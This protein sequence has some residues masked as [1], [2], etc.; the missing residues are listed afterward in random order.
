MNKDLIIQ[1]FCVDY[2]V[3][4]DGETYN[5]L[6]LFADEVF[7]TEILAKVLDSSN[8]AMSD[9]GRKIRPNIATLRVLLGQYINERAEQKRLETM[10]GVTPDEYCFYCTAGY[11]LGIQQR[12]GLWGSTLT[13]GRCECKQGNETGYMAHRKPV[14]PPQ[15]IQD[16]AREHSMDCP[17]AADRMV[18]ERTQGYRDEREP[19][20]TGPQVASEPPD[21]DFGDGWKPE[22]G[23]D[24]IPF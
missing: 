13:I 3:K 19:P 9:T 22:P 6:T 23:E 8:H 2:D 4:R 14:K 24:P 7:S 5:N 17:W 18:Y 1:K 20:A 21:Y 11:V 15:E 16:Y 12:M 10:S